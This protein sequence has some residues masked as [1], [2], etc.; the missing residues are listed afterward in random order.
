MWQA[1]RHAPIKR[2]ITRGNVAKL[3]GSKWIR[4][5]RRL[6][7]Y[8]RDSFSCVYCGANLFADYSSDDIRERCNVTLD[9]LVARSQTEQPDN[10]ETNLVTCCLSCNSRRQDQPWQSFAKGSGKSRSI[11]H[12]T[13]LVAKPLDMP[14]AK[15]VFALKQ[16]NPQWRM[17]ARV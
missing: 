12:I 15:A 1:H 7:I 13:R 14:R 6:A 17:H 10:S 4:D 16:S 2:V 3:N 9:H 8:M 5:E 11:I